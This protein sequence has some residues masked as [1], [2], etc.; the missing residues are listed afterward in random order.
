V[1]ALSLVASG[2]PATLARQSLGALFDR[3]ARG[4]YEPVAREL[5]AQLT[6]PDRVAAF[7]KDL[8]GQI[9][10][11]PRNTAAAFALEA[12]AAAFVVD[13]RSAFDIL[14]LG[15][16]RL[17]EVRP[18]SWELDWQI[19][20]M[21]LTLEPPSPGQPPALVQL[22]A[23]PVMGGNDLPSGRGVRV[24][25]DRHLRVRFPKEPLIALAFGLLGEAQLYYSQ[26][27]VT[28]VFTSPVRSSASWA[29][30]GRF[31]SGVDAKVI[32]APFEDVLASSDASLRAEAMLHLGFI[33]NSEKRHDEALRL[34]AQVRAESPEPRVQYLA[35]LFRARALWGV[36][37]QGDKAIAALEDA[38]TVRPGAHAASVSLA[39]L[40]F[41]SQQPDR[42]AAVIEAQLAADPETDDP[43]RSYLRGVSLRWPARLRIVREGLK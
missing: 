38:L 30:T 22:A 31:G 3:Y 27:I 20:A 40:Y 41:L 2:A 17:R 6:S 23:D 26:Q 21:A 29:G 7:R 36:Q 37:D 35:S 8:A 18:T 14:E 25:H 10:N 16:D 43:W 15:C 19:A 34:W 39:A 12:S 4:E 9:R 24:E 42:A 28:P 1:I 13:R 32:A 33:R 11:W 5:A